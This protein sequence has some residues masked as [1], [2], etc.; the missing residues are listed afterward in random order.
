LSAACRQHGG[1][2]GFDHGRRLDGRGLDGRGL[3]GRGFH[4]RGLDWRWLYRRR[5]DGIH[6][7]HWINGV[8]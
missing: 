3:D 1:R 6:G 4:G 5:I 2:H 8:G 7:I